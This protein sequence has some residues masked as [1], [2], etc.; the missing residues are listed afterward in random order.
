[1]YIVEQDQPVIVKDIVVTDDSGSTGSADG[2]SSDGST[3][4]SSDGGSSD[5]SSDGGSTDGSTDGS[6]SAPD[7]EMIEGFGGASIE[8]DTF[9]FP[10]GSEVWAGF[11][12]LNTDIYP[13]T[14]RQWRFH[15]LY[16][17]CGCWW[18]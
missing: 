3:D 5:G 1:M 17:S 10:S 11:A 12:N 8:G 6:V 13:F 18:Q 14:F 15:Y 9:T 4:G 2:G 7:V 16:R